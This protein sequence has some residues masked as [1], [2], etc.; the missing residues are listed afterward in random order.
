LT[1]NSSQRRAA[2][3]TSAR[4]DVTSS[5]FS[6]GRRHPSPHSRIRSVSL[7]REQSRFRFNKLRL[8]RRRNPPS[9]APRTAFSSLHESP[10]PSR[11][12][13]P[14]LSSREVKALPQWICRQILHGTWQHWQEYIAILLAAAAKKKLLLLQQAKIGTHV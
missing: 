12:R 11:R 13:R 1:R 14:K 2:V 10:K 8:S 5:S 6:G 7:L 9:L 4:D 3:E